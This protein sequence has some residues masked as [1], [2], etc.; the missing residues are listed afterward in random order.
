MFSRSIRSS[1][2]DLR[3]IKIPC[4][5]DAQQ[6]IVRAHFKWVKPTM[7]HSRLL[8]QCAVSVIGHTVSNALTFGTQGKPVKRKL[9]KAMMNGRTLTLRMWESA[10]I[11]V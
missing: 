7:K 9:I 10:R 11:A 1:L 5:K 3:F 4:S 8:L 2:R 6:S